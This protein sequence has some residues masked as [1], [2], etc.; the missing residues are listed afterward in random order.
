MS[1]PDECLKGIPNESFITQDKK[2]S[3]HLFYFKDEHIRPD[4][5]CRQ[6]INWNDDDNSIQHTLNQKNNGNVQFKIGV[7]LLS[8]AELDKISRRPLI[9]GMLSYERDPLP[10]N[11]YHGNL[12][13]KT[14]YSDRTMK[15][16]AATISMTA[17]E[18][19]V[20]QS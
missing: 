10:D 11:R 9:N 5:W 20:E 4:G 19:I 17:C 12:L 16:V 7:V 3:A 6:S 1:Y 18:R 2:I 13:L 8:R 15:M 14:D